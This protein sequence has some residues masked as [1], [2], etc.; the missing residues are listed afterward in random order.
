MMKNSNVTCMFLRLN[1]NV[2]YLFE[3]SVLVVYLRLKV[4]FVIDHHCE[5][6]IRHFCFTPPPP[7]S[8][9]TG[10]SLGCF[11]FLFGKITL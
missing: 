9:Y 7:K 6:K 2:Q 11:W 4:E 10:I 8:Q 1:I 5:G 3:I